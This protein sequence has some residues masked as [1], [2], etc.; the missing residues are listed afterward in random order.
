MPGSCNLL[1]CALSAG[2]LLVSATLMPDGRDYPEECIHRF[3]EEHSV[4]SKGKEGDVVINRRTGEQRVLPPCHLKA[5]LEVQSN[6]SV[7]Y[8][9]SW[10]VDTVSVHQSIGYMAT[11]WTVPKAPQSRGPTG[12]SSMYLFNGLEDGGGVRGASTFILQPV[13]SH[14]KSG[15]VLNPFAGWEFTSFQVTG[16]GRA[17][18]GRHFSVKEGDMLQGIMQ[19]KEGNTWDIISDAGRRGK[20]VHTAVLQDSQK[21]DS[22]YLTLEGMIV[23]NCKS[24]PDTGVDFIANEL[25][26]KDGKALTPK[27]RTD[28]RHNECQ[29]TT[30]IK[31]DTVSMKWHNTDPAEHLV[32]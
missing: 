14:G 29:P 13:L 28:V 22:A 18:C 17:Y 1:T 31:G 11:N 32:V 8:Y 24:L 15:C 6:S 26:D 23:Y 30:E 27:W 7:G 16:A 4:V 10:I 3:D 9:S 2:S 19:L 20:S 21:I 25:A 12:L 5:A